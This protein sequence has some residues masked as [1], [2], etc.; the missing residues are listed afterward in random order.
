MENRKTISIRPSE[1]DDLKQF[2]EWE[3]QDNVKRFFSIRDGQTFEEVARTYVASDE[4][5]AQRQF[6]IEL[7]GKMIGRIV[8]A[9]IIEG[10]KGELL[11]IYIGDPANRG[12]GYGKQAMEWTM[13]YCFR[14]LGLQRLYLDYYTGN[15]AQFLYEKLGFQHE[16]MLRKNCRKNGVLYDVHLM[17]MLAEEYRESRT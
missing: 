7:D 11:R 6:T 13:D 8:L 5:P 1:W 17:S 15:P 3:L 16:G 12:Q 14:R 9:D 2:Y 10:W 4:D